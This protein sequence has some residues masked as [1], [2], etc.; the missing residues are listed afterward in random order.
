MEERN[1]SL[2]LE[3]KT[4]IIKNNDAESFCEFHLCPIRPVYEIFYLSTPQNYLTLLYTGT[5]QISKIL[6]WNASPCENYNIC[7]NLR[8]MWISLMPWKWLWADVSSISPS[9]EQEGSYGLGEG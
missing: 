6:Q 2:M 3:I 4:F 9:S 8:L 5:F 1:H 7:I